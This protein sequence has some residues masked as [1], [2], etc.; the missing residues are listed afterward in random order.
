MARTGAGIEASTVLWAA[1]VQASQASTQLKMAKKQLR[2][3]ELRA[4]FAGVVAALEGDGGRL[5]HV[6]VVGHVLVG[7]VRRF[8]LHRRVGVEAAGRF[9]GETL[10]QGAA[11]MAAGG[12]DPLDVDDV[13]FM[14]LRLLSAGADDCVHSS[15]RLPVAVADATPRVGAS[16]Q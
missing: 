2:D 8:D 14:H 15:I 4:P 6:D 5:L 12:L 7:P 16:A 3:T 11:Q 1:G 10:C 13:T 9:V